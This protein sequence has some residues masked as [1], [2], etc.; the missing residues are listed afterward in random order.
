MSQ[1]KQRERLKTFSNMW[2]NP[3]L[4]WAPNVGS[5]ALVYSWSVKFL[6]P[7]LVKLAQFFVPFH[8]FDRNCDCP[9]FHTVIILVESWFCCF[10]LFGIYNLHNSTSLFTPLTDIMIVKSFTPAK[11]CN[12]W[13]VITWIERWFCCFGLFGINDLHNFTSLFT[14]LIDKTFASS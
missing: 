11:Y 1:Y 9:N 10:G 13:S 5:H 8:P 3:R 7:F 6:A 2:G 4:L 14:P 12:T